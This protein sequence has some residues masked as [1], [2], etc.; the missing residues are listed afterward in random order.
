M[1]LPLI[2]GLTLRSGEPPKINDGRDGDEAG[3]GHGVAKRGVAAMLA[4]GACMVAIR[5]LMQRKAR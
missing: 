5:L 1:A 3:T 4:V 2:P